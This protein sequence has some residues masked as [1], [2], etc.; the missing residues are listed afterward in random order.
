MSPDVVERTI[1]VRCGLERAFEIFTAELDSWWP[2][3]HSLSGNPKT[4]IRL[5]P[6]PDGRLY[7]H[8]PEGAE[9]TWGRVLIWDPPRQLAFHWY[10]GSNSEQPSL[11]DIRFTATDD[12]QTRVVVSHRGPEL[13]G[14]LWAHNAPRYAAA[15]NHLLP[16][17][18]AICAP[19]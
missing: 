11:V 12:G 18:A 10:L 1:V 19:H 9:L 8:T 14:D 2:K 16:S 13:L 5:E 17:F 4:S 3:T 6:W 15:W 7:E